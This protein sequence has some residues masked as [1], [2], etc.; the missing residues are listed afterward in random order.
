MKDLTGTY[1]LIFVAKTRLGSTHQK[2]PCVSHLFITEWA[3]T[4][5][6]LL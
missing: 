5:G 6:L 2:S 4:S 3:F 1:S